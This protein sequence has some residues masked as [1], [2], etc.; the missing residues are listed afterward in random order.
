VDRLVT[1][2][3]IFREKK[4]HSLRHRGKAGHSPVARA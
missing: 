4:S 2:K 1:K 3:P